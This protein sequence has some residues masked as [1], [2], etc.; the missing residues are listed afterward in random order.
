MR[1]WERIDGHDRAAIMAHQFTVIVALISPHR[2]HDR[3][4]I[5]VLGSLLSAVRFDQVGW[6]VSIS[7][8]SVVL[9]PFRCPFDE[10]PM[11]RKTPRVATV[12]GRSGCIVTI[13][14]RSPRDHV[15]E[16]QRSRSF[17]VSPTISGNDPCLAHV[18]LVWWRSGDRDVS[19]R[20]QVGPPS[21][22]LIPYFEHVRWWMIVWTRVHA[23][24]A[25]C[26][27]P[28]PIARPRRL[29]RWDSTGHSPTRN[30]KQ[31]RVRLNTGAV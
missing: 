7:R 10:D 27:D 20:H 16:D 29:H 17:H 3:A 31:E 28:T 13:W 1:S 22:P 12:R 30:K 9:M 21:N 19:T 5:V 11:L 2:S 25:S 23:I 24:D 15:D 26:L 18:F 4:S 6:T 14:S 8:F